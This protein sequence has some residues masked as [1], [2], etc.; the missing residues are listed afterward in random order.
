MWSLGPRQF[1]R[2]RLGCIL[3]VHCV[4]LGSG[5]SERDPIRAYITPET[6]SSGAQKHPSWWTL[7]TMVS[8][9]P[10]AVAILAAGA[11]VLTAPAATYFWSS[12]TDGKAKITQNNGPDGKFSVKWSGDKGNFVIGKGWNTG[13]SRYL[14]HPP[15]I[16][17]PL[18]RTTDQSLEKSSTPA[19]SHPKATA[20]SPSMAGP[21]ARSSNTTSSKPMVTTTPRT[22]PRPRSR[23][24]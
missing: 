15:I 20:T 2:G 3:G 17:S 5:I 18:Q 16:N 8:F 6:H 23:A 21:R 9:T 4:I 19:P 7:N 14:P 12:W 24:T 22:T 13:S 1:S 10:F 11:G